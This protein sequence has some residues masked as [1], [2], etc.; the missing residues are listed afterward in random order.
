VP[1]LRPLGPDAPRLIGGYA[2]FG[3]IGQGGQ[4]VVYFGRDPGGAPVAVKVLHDGA[5]GNPDAHRRFLREV[6][7]ARRVSPFCTARVLDV[8][9]HD[10]RPYIVSEFVPGASLEV[11]VQEQG[12]RTGGGLDRLA[13]ATASALAAIHR[14]GI[15]HRDF[16]PANVILGP[17]GPVV[18]DFGISMALDHAG[19]RTGSVGTPAY[20]APE[21]FARDTAGQPADVFAW[22]GTMVF[23]ASGRRPFPGDTMPVILQGILNSQPDLSGVPEALRPLLAECLNKDPAL[24]P[25]ASELYDVLSG[26][27]RSV[28]PVV[29]PFETNPT[30]VETT[31][32]SPRR[33]P[34]GVAGVVA[35]VAALAA[36]IVLVPLLLN[37]TNKDTGK[38]ATT[39]SAIPTAPA[40][41]PAPAIGSLIGTPITE[42]SND[43]RSIAIGDVNGQT[44]AI[45]GSDDHTVRRWDLKLAK[46]AGAALL[47]HT[48]WVMSVAYGQFNGGPIAA[49][50]SVDGT[51]RI[52]N[53]KDGALL[54]TLKGHQGQVRAMTLTEVDGKVIAV[55]AGV[56]GTVRVWSLD[57]MTQQGA[58]LTE[59][60]GAVNAVAVTQVDGG[61]VAVTTGDDKTVRMWDLKNRTEVGEAMTGH[62][63][64]VVSVGTGQLDGKPVAVSAS[65]DGSL[66]VW[67]LTAR[68]QLG[69]ALTGGNW[70]RVVT[71][72]NLRGK[73]I[74][75]SGG[76]DGAVRVWDLTKGKQ[77]APAFKGH[78]D[79]VWAVALTTLPTGPVVMSGSRDNTMRVWS[80]GPEA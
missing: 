4:G 6:D 56:D 28:P 41:A 47:G 80:L 2:L 1:E 23:A 8:G 64:R 74:A 34:W 67:D 78:T 32:S 60:E 77:L 10:G 13:V 72:G 48:G 18:I 17:E 9:L 53:L 30:A 7:V 27:G 71:V 35:A 70:L 61:P 29:S 49:S 63:D 44:V 66:R 57:T 59:H 21:Q 75:V 40:S 24:R 45:S 3:L 15:V 14:A 54:G 26:V 69:K 11:L 19:T 50:S 46:P 25:T 76:E 51:V 36:A 79:R 38:L 58:P 37:S 22:A 55:T 68:S 16:K 20:M 62:T 5:A 52:W 65:K 73:P 43:I 39:G 12:P 33:F 31:Q 42:H